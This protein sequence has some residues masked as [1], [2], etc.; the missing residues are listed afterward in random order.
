M[1][2]ILRNQVIE[3]FAAARLGEFEHLLGRA[4]E[5][6]IPIELMAERLL[7]LSLLWERIEELP[8]EVIFGGIRP[9]ERLVVLNENQ[10]KLFDEKPGWSA[11][12]S[13]TR[14]GTGTSSWIDRRSTTRCSPDST[15]PILTP[16]AARRTARSSS[17]RA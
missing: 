17:S 9:E 11:R 14:W 10:R 12:R 5:P 16:S 13:V 2:K 8:G 1:T 15:V 3:D 7:G 6:P 4:L